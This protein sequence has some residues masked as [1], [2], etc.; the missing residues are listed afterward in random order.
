MTFRKQYKRGSATASG[1]VNHQENLGHSVD[2]RGKLAGQQGGVK[3][4]WYVNTASYSGSGI[5][6]IWP[7]VQEQLTE[8]D[9]AAHPS[10]GTVAKKTSRRR[11]NSASRA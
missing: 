11:K 8:S 9:T 4:T 2:C 1:P 3:G 5:F 7:A 6:H 10:E